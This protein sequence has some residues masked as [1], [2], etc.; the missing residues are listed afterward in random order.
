MADRMTTP[1]V[2]FEAR[3][4]TG[5]LLAAHR[6]RPALVRLRYNPPLLVFRAHPTTAFSGSVCSRS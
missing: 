2:Q 6:R 1:S 5:V 3:R 4:R